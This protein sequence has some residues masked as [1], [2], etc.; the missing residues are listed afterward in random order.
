MNVEIRDKIELGNSH[1]WDSKN[2]GLQINT[3]TVKKCVKL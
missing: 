3:T 2:A 1:L